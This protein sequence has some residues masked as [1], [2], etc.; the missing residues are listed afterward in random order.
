MK[1]AGV[2]TDFNRKLLCSQDWFF[3][4]LYRDML[5]A[6]FSKQGQVVPEGIIHRFNRHDLKG[7]FKELDD[8][9]SKRADMTTQTQENP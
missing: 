4:Q 8:P 7:N 5:R 3:S 2:V 1:D 9:L 6:F